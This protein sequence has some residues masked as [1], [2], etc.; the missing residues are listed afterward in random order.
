MIGSME[1]QGSLFYVAFGQQASLIKDD[2][3]EPIDALLDDRPLIGAVRRALE[4]RHPRSGSTGRK[5]MAPDRLLRCCALKHLKRWSF[6]ELER[7]LR[8]SLVYRRFTRFDSDPIPDHG[9]LSRNFAV[10]DETAVR[11]IQARVVAV[12]R[13]KR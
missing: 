2:L 6:R 5:G 11:A 13:V 7:E 3:L 9:T 12:A 1:R 4:R 10:L 8:S